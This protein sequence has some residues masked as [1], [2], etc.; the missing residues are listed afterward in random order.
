MTHTSFHTL[1]LFL[2][3][4][5]HNYGSILQLC[6]LVKQLTIF[7]VKCLHSYNVYTRNNHNKLITEAYQNKKSKG[8]HSELETLSHIVIGLQN[9]V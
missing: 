5:A 4:P 9:F 7:Q 2:A 6:I 3:Y 1:K 8:S